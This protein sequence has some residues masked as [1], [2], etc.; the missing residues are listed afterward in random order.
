MPILECISKSRMR[1]EDYVVVKSTRQMNLGDKISS[2]IIST[3]LNRE[4]KSLLMKPPDIVVFVKNVPRI[5]CDFRR[6]D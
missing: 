4:D 2:H 6:F 3:L 5:T 1:I